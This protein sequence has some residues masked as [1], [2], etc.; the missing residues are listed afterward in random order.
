M[1]DCI[2]L[3][4]L[5]N[6]RESKIRE[7]TFNR[8][9]V[10]SIDKNSLMMEL[11]KRSP[12]AL[13]VDLDSYE[14]STLEMIQSTVSIDYLPVIYI[15]DRFNDINDLLKHEIVVHIN[16]L[17]GTLVALL[18]QSSIFKSKYDNVMESYNAIDLINGEFKSFFKDYV[19]EEDDTNKMIKKS[20]D[21]VFANNLF[22]NNK[23]EII[24]VLT[25]QN[26][27]YDTIKFQMSNGEYTEKL[28]FKIDKNDFFNFDIY[29][30]NGFSRNYNIN[31]LSDISINDR[32]FPN[33]IKRN[34]S[35]I[36]NFTG[37]TIGKIILIGMNYDNPVSNYDIG[38]IKALAIN[39][40]LLESIKSQMNEL[41][42]AFEYTTNA[43]AR[44]AEVND[45]IT[46]QHIKRVNTFAKRIAE[47][48]G[49]NKEFV[50]HIY[51]SSQM[52]DVGK[53]Y[54]EKEILTKP[55]KLSKE[56]FEKIKMH[57]VFGE[58]IVGDSEYLKMSAEI[59]RSHHERYDG[60]GYP[61][62]KKGEEIPIAARIVFLADIYDALRS[63]RSYKPPFSHE[64]AYQIITKGDGRVNPEHFDPNVLETFKKAHLD[65]KYIYEE[66]GD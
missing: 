20:L 53:I 1:S 29:G 38:I 52:H 64:K 54:V 19:Y 11:Y 30:S 37:F 42:G 63:E 36:K 31:E 22:L 2:F 16:E 14:D 65:F 10:Y 51:N 56:E 25:A 50:K 7:Y 27:G 32:N 61:D 33:A 60:T 58:K 28:C 44:A 62:G 57:T 17:E 41:E 45:D 3:M 39:F 40:D 5:N 13:I 55:G 23:P 34:I 18:K 12:R 66:L 26:N 49:M 4:T 59:A 6:K 46:G 48:L 35:E 8:Y 43:L 9:Q 24:W 47:G 21:L 15:Y